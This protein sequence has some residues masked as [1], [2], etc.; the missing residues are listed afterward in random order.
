MLAGLAALRERSRRGPVLL[1]LALSAVAYVVTLPLRFIPAAWETASRAGEFLFIGVGLI[2]A[3]GLIWLFERGGGER[4]RRRVLGVVAIVIIF[5]SGVIAGWPS[6]E[7]LAP[8]RRVVADGHTLD[9][10]QLVAALWSGRT[11]GPSQRAFAQNAD[12]RFLVVNGHQTAYEGAGT[13]DV[14]D[15]LNSTTPLLPWMRTALRNYHITLVMTDRRMISADNIM[16]F[17]WDVGAPPLSPFSTQKKFNLP[18]VDRLYDGGNIAIYG[19]RG[20]W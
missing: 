3:L 15:V 8:A 9:P 6:T 11:L 4:P 20:L 14:Q 7:R 13:P 19:V 2:T 1:F 12:A 10:P 17:F 5:A 16:G 18:D